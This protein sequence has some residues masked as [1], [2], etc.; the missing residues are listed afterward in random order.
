MGSGNHMTFFGK[1]ANPFFIATQSQSFVKAAVELAF[2]FFNIPI[3]SLGFYFV[4]TTTEFPCQFFS[5][6]LQDFLTVFGTFFSLLFMGNN[7]T[8]NFKVCVDLDKI[9]AT[10]YGAT[11]RKDK[12]SYTLI[13]VVLCRW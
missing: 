12:L 4:K 11:S 2:Q 9:D 7:M 3:L 5:Q 8:T 10:S 6:S 13:K 1:F